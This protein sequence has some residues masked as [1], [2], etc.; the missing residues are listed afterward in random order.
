MQ[1]GSQ[2]QQLAAPARPASA[3]PSVNDVVSKA[4]S[5]G[6]VRVA[7]PAVPSLSGPSRGREV[8]VDAWAWEAGHAN[9]LFWF[10]P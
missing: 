10:P 9:R 1:T 2:L 5:P 3:L 4:T 8:P 6:A 7:V